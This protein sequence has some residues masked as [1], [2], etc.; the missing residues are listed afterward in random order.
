MPKDSLTVVDN[1]TGLS[2]ELPITDGTVRAT[3]LRK[4]RSGE[5]DFGLM[6]YDPGFTNTA[7]T[8]SSI[9]Y[10]DGEKGVLR[11]RGYPIETLAERANYL[12]TAYLVIYGRL[13]TSPQ[14]PKSQ[15]P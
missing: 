11:Y 8:R 12:E 10:V 2:Y 3:D 5:E 15:L 9:T 13:P 6:S 7:S 14:S 4:I 1:R